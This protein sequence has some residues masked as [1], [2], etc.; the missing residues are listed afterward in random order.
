MSSNNSSGIRIDCSEPGC[1]KSFKRENNL[2]RHMNEVHGPAVYARMHCGSKIRERTKDDSN[3]KR[4]RSSEGFLASVVKYGVEMENG[5]H[6]WCVKVVEEM[7]K[8]RSTSSAGNR[9][10]TG[11]GMAA[12]WE[13][14]DSICT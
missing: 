9:R 8:D 5:E 7:F 6:S 10:R 12:I 14:Q 13:Y 3:V 4:H 2:E 1:N 11:I